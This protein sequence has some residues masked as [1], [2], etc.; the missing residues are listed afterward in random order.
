M[1]LKQQP[2]QKDIKCIHLQKQ[3]VSVVHKSFF[4]PWHYDKRVHSFKIIS[5]LRLMASR[6]MAGFY[7]RTSGT[8]ETA[9]DDRV[10]FFLYVCVEVSLMRSQK[11]K[12]GTASLDTFLALLHWYTVHTKERQRKKTVFVRH[13]SLKQILN[14]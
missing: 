1:G 14:T 9:R 12:W 10:L 6:V 7:S 11:Q 3:I 13:L 4:D 5:C 2:Y 8:E